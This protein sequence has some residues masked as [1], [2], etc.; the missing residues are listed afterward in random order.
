MNFRRAYRCGWESRVLGC[1][2]TQSTLSSVLSRFVVLIA[3][4]NSTSE[5]GKGSDEI[6]QAFQGVEKPTDG[7]ERN[8]PVEVQNE[9]CLSFRDTCRKVEIEKPVASGYANDGTAQDTMK[10][11]NACRSR[12]HTPT[13]KVATRNVHLTYSRFS[14]RPIF[15]SNRMDTFRTGVLR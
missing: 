13:E 1:L 12:V 9:N 10:P 11:V 14:T 8:Y 5:A 2:R 6:G 4:Q 7:H 15:S 3:Q